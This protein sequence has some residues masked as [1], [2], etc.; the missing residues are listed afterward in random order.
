MTLFRQTTYLQNFVPTFNVPR[1]IT[2]F[3]RLNLLQTNLL[4]VTII[5]RVIKIIKVRVVC[6]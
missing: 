1:K 4:F 2:H 6:V 5:L 3:L